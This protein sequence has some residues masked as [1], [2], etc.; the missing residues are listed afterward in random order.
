MDEEPKAKEKNP[1]RTQTN[2]GTCLVYHFIG[3]S[4]LVF[5]RG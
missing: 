4:S 3:G 2:S 5:A 1:H